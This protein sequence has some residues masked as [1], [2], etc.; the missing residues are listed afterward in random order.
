MST[1]DIEVQLHSLTVLNEADNK[2]PF[3]PLSKAY[4]EVGNHINKRIYIFLSFRHNLMK[5]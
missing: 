5:S 1:G 3:L 4:E 2:L